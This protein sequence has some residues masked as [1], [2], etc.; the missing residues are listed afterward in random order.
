MNLSRRF[1]LM[2]KSAALW[3]GMA[4]AVLGVLLAA[5]GFLVAGFFLWVSHHMGNDLAAVITGG[6]LIAV[7][8]IIA[9]SGFAILKGMRRKQPSLLAEFGGT[10]GLALRLAGLVVRRDPK[11]AIIISI[12]AGALAEYITSERKR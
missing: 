9:L 5:L 6:V 2:L 4:I 1:G 3:A 12:I 10:I 7:A 8:I 11:K